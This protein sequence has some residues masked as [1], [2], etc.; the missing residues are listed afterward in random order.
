[1]AL[2]SSFNDLCL[3]RLEICGR[4]PSSEIAASAKQAAPHYW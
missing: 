3:T 4:H 2:I 1:M